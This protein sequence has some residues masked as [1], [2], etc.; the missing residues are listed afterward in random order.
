MYKDDVLSRV[1][2]SHWFKVFSE[3]RINIEEE[4]CSGGPSSSRNIEKWTEF[5]ISLRSD[6]Q[7]SVRMIGERLNLNT[8]VVHSI[9]MEELRIRKIC[10]KIV[11]KNLSQN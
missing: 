8:T 5:K 11:P 1:Q 2:V 3:G 4:P 6:R 9:L 7:L 10:V